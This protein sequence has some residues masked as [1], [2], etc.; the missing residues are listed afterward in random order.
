MIQIILLLYVPWARTESFNVI[1]EKP[2]QKRCDKTLN[3]IG[4]ESLITSLWSMC[5]LCLPQ[6]RT[7][8]TKNTVV[9]YYDDNK[10]QELH[11]N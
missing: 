1:R 2:K 8:S 3:K 4:P 6:P 9:P 10:L 5:G 11:S 7:T